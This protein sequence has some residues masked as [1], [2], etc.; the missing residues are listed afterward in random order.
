[1]YLK[2]LK[3]D[4]SSNST[5]FNQAE[6]TVESKSYRGSFEESLLKVVAAERKS[7]PTL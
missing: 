7:T 6:V 4:H 5:N 1:M 2:N 3:Q